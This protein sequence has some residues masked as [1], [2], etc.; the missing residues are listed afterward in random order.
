MTLSLLLGVVAVAGAAD[1]PKAPPAMTPDQQKMM[2]DMTKAMM[3]GEHHKRLDSM[4]GRWS[5]HVK[6]WL[7]PNSPAMETSG[8]M[9]A[10]W[11]MG[12]R[13]LVSHHTG[14]MMGMPFEGQSVDGY[15]NLSKKYVSSWIDNM[16]TGIL[17][18][19]GDCDADC[20]VLTET[21][22]MIDPSSGNRIMYKSVIT[23]VDANT[24]KYEAYSVDAAGTATKSM[25]LVGTRKH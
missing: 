6:L 15:D 12:G 23:F 10:K 14:N 9:E 1:P 22:E 25:E 5:T 20:K 19:S 16:G 11:I 13:Y 2:D 24:Y 4:A 8:S 17:N 21:G 7:A 18:L 3:P